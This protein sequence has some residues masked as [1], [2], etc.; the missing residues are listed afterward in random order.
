M[1]SISF[2]ASYISA[3]F[4]VFF[5]P[6]V[7][8]WLGSTDY[9]LPYSFVIIYSLTVYLGAV[10]EI[11][12]KYRSVFGDYRQDRICMLVS[13]VLNIVIS[14]T[15]AY[16]LGVTGVQIRTLFGYIPIAYG[17]VRFVVV[18]YFGKSVKKYLLKHTGLFIVAAV[19]E[20]AAF[21]LTKDIP[22]TI[23]GIALRF[24]IWGI[25]PL[26]VNLLIYFKN[27][28]FKDMFEYFKSLIE[29]LKNKVRKNNG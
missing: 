6:A 9:L 1:F 18:N 14:V 4:I 19:E 17:R 27:P 28:H 16:K 2:F 3:G 7:Q 22:V 23:M 20:I 12:Y 11:V 24:V 15:L 13:A 8:I 10:W 25:V 26:A 29:I 5:Q 21:F